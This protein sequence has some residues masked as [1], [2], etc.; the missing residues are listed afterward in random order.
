MSNRKCQEERKEDREVTCRAR[1][2]G[3]AEEMGDW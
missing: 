2:G 1:G 3:T